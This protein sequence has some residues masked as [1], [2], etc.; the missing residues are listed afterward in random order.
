[1]ASAAVGAA[2]SDVLCEGCGQHSFLLPLHGG[3]GGPLRCPLCVGAWN[4]EHGRKRRTGRIVIRAIMAF[5]DAGGSPK[6][7]DK[8]K[9]TAA[10]AE[11]GRL[12]DTSE[13][14]AS[15]TD[16]LGYMDGIARLDGADVDLTSELLADVLRL[17]HPDHHPPERK[18]LAHQVT[19]KLLALQPFVFPAPKPKPKPPPL[20]EAATSDYPISAPEPESKPSPPRYP[21]ADCADALSFDYCDACKAEWEKRQQKEFEQRTKKQRAEY[22]RRR[23]RKLRYRPQRR[24]EAC[25]AEFKRTRTDA[26]YCSATC[27]QRAHRQAVTDKSSP[28]YGTRSSRHNGAWERGILALLKRHPAVYLNDLLPEKRTR[29]QYQALSLAAVK[30]EAE[31]KIDSWWFGGMWGRPGFKALARRDLKVKNDGID[32]KQI[33]RLTDEERLAFA[34]GA[35]RLG[36]DAA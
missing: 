32:E 11:L 26:R 4:A 25:G 1:M 5:Y 29:A 7:L 21:C 8:L 2:M 27:R 18:L 14:F 13:L 19:Q 12:F 28:T 35:R 24:C 16:P 20:P 6:D 31:G 15:F 17:A 10:H 34:S 30:L 3:K 23:E 9:D 22:K 33:H 36:A